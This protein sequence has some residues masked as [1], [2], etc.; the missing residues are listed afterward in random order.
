MRGSM[1]D[2]FSLVHLQVP[3]CHR[4]VAM[5][6]AFRVRGTQAVDHFRQSVFRVDYERIRAFDLPVQIALLKLTQP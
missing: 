3:L 6:D 2:V 1:T 4:R 5:G